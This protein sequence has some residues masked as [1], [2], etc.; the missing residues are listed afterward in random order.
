LANAT[1][2]AAACRLTRSGQ[3]RGSDHSAKSRSRDDYERERKPGE[4][5]G[6]A[7]EGVDMT[8]PDNGEVA[9]VG[10]GDLDEPLALH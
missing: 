5:S 3:R 8:W 1:V 2:G 4:S 9:V 10:R 7:N 6:P